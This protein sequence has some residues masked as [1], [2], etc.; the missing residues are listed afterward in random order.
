MAASILDAAYER[1]KVP[2]LQLLIKHNDDWGGFTPFQ[3]AMSC[4]CY[5][6]VQHEA[7]QTVLDEAWY[8]PGFIKLRFS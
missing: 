4:K 6:V 5:A 1:D 7:F 8:G 3:L 2:A